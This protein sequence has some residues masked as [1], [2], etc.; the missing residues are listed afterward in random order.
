MTMV[1]VAIKINTACFILSPWIYAG[2]RLAGII[3]FPFDWLV[4]F[5]LFP[6]SLLA[7]FF[8][9]GRNG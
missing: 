3:N 4:F 8:N 9:F 5:F 2:L 6:A 1:N 7:V